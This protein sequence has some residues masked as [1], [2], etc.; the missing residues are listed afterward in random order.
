MVVVL[1]IHL[2]IV[3]VIRELSIYFILVLL[4]VTCL[5]RGNFIQIPLGL[6]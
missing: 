2:I 3:G 5:I 1:Q 6:V 4:S